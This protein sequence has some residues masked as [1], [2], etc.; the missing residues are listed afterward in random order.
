VNEEGGDK[1]LD[2]KEGPEIFTELA[3][4]VLLKKK[5]NTSNMVILARNIS[6][7]VLYV[8]MTVSPQRS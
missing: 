6:Y 2:D 1:E 7:S 4:R 8:R 3:R 5:L